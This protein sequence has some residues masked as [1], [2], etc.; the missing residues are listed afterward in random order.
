M[1]RWL[2]LA[3]LCSLGWAQNTARM[4]SGVN[5][6]TGTSYTFVAADTTKLVSFS[7]GSSI[8]A[9]LPAPTTLGLNAGLIFSVVN[10]GA[11]TVTITCSGCTINGATTLALVNNQGADIYNDGTNYAALSTA[12][13]SATLPSGQLAQPLMNNNGTTGYATSPLFW[14]AS[15]FAG[16]T[17]DVKLNTANAYAITTGHGVLNASSLDGSQTIGAQV[18][19]G[20]LP[21]PNV[22]AGTSGT[23]STGTFYIAYSLTSSQIAETTSSRETVITTGGACTTNCSLTITTPT[24]V[25]T[26]TAWAVYEGTSRWNMLL[27]G[28]VGGTAIGSNITITSACTGKNV[29]TVFSN[30]GTPNVHFIPPKNGNWTVT[31]TQG[32]GFC[33]LMFTNLSSMEDLSSGEGRPWLIKG[34]GSVNL[35]AL[36]CTDPDPE[37][38]GQAPGG[39]YHVDGISAAATSGDTYHIAPLVIQ[40]VF[41]KSKFLDWHGTSSVSG[42]LMWVY[43]TCCGTIIEAQMECFYTGG[44]IPLRVGCV[45]SSGPCTNYSGIVTNSTVFLAPSLV[46]P[47][48]TTNCTILGENCPNLEFYSGGNNISFVGTTYFETNS[49]S[50]GD[51]VQFGTGGQAGGPFNFDEVQVGAGT[52]CGYLYALA[53]TNSILGFRAG[54]T[55]NGACTNV[56]KIGATGKITGVTSNSTLPEITYDANNPVYNLSLAVP[57]S[58]A[59]ASAPTSAQYEGAYYTATNCNAACTVGGTCTAG[60]STHCEVRFNGSSWVETG[61]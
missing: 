25:G 48:N 33:G 51:V 11:G 32:A 9:T 2:I 58:G 43:G 52:G 12:A 21:Q 10:V 24:Y 59:I 28:S 23:F 22:T 41:D 54:Q 60:A 20:A 61:R 36:V 57:P 55:R 49:S 38:T 13:I 34:N 8:A 37:G 56:L 6:Q 44:C 4:V 27:C 47:G 29:S 7:N 53:L 3:L 14:D 40:F 1:K 45:V 46:H 5:Y 15:L 31:S 42:P 18:T 30:G 35:D 26:A 39:Y 17:A 16:A 19:I 50:T